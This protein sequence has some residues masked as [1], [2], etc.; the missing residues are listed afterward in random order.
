MPS[1]DFSSYIDLTPYDA[2]PSEIYSAAVEYATTSMPDFSPRTGT[3]ED[4]M[5]QAMSYVSG[6]L[7]ASIN[8][9]PNSLM[10][11]VL[12][13]FGFDRNEATLS[14]GTIVLT[15]LG[16][17]GTIYAG[18]QFSYE[19]TVDGQIN[20]YVFSAL[21]NTSVALNDFEVEINVIST[22]A[23]QIPTISSGSTMKLLTANSLIISA[24]AG[25]ITSGTDSED[26][27]SYFTRAVTYFQS[28]SDGLITPRQ[29]EAHV[30]SSYPVITR[31]KSISPAITAITDSSLYDLTGID[32][33]EFVGNIV[34]YVLSTGGTFT[35]QESLVSI[36]SGIEQ[37]SVPGLNVQV[38][39]P[40]FVK[41]NCSTLVE[42]QSGYDRATVRD[43]VTTEL[44]SRVSPSLWDY[45]VNDISSAI[46]SSLAIKYA[47]GVNY[48]Y[49]LG[50][51]VKGFQTAASLNPF[52]DIYES[53]SVG[54]TNFVLY[55]LSSTEF[56]D[57]S[58]MPTRP[59]TG[60]QFI[61]SVSISTPIYD[62]GYA[63]EFA[64]PDSYEVVRKGY[65]IVANGNSGEDVIRVNIGDFG[66][67]ERALLFKHGLSVEGTGIPS[68]TFILTISPYSS[69]YFDI[70]ISKHLTANI[71]DD[72]IIIAGTTA[73]TIAGLSASVDVSATPTNSTI[74]T[75]DIDS[76]TSPVSNGT[77]VMLEL[78]EP[79]DFVVDD[80]IYVT[81][82]K[83]LDLPSYNPFV[84][85]HTVSEVPSSTSIKY[86]VDYQGEVDTTLGSSGACVFHYPNYSMSTLTADFDIPSNPT[87]A[88][89]ITN[90][91]YNSEILLT[92][93]GYLPKLSSADISINVSE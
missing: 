60:T 35:D 23:G 92:H 48:V 77:Y 89:D 28:L 58:F 26:D 69:E 59:Y 43:S 88:S 90:A 54:Y 76:V 47:E 73:L 17:A 84:G 24:V 9:L 34:A 74:K 33:T 68:G 8:R 93:I 12:N 63:N 44:S 4:A 83:H 78:T 1:P 20:Q 42:K 70:Q 38:V 18:T 10:E 87:P 2:Q 21:D 49:S 75:Y 66:H 3:V 72:E 31:V 91:E 64:L 46:L 52:G 36:A 62:S 39:N 67:A 29:I 32:K 6:F 51:A 82:L 37:R 27:T 79:H 41:L 81:G 86:L 85:E 15:L 55:D 80:T 57:D 65:K 13:V 7:A 40:I 14:S 30:L 5:L 16:D 19:E 56:V 50:L 22:S 71:T 11:G 45:A 25:T 53:A 61:D